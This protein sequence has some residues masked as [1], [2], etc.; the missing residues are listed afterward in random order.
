MSIGNEIITVLSRVVNS[1]KSINVTRGATPLNHF[2]GATVSTYNAGYVI[3]LG[4]TVGDASIFSYNSTTQKIV[5]VYNYGQTVSSINPIDLSTVFFDQE[6]RLAGMISV[7]DPIRCFEFS[8]DN[9]SFTRNQLIDIKEDYRYIFDSSHSSM[10][11]V[12]F[13]I[14]PSKNLNLKTLEALRGNNVLDVKFG[15]GPRIATNNYSTKSEV[16]F[17]NKI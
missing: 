5:F 6:Q 8:L 7:Q 13:D 9:T 12:E 2:N 1:T 4:T 3:S 10:S 17:N 14:S 15:F 16:S 11:D